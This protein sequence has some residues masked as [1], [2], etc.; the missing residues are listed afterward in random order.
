[1]DG[2]RYTLQPVNSSVQVCDPHGRVICSCNDPYD[3]P[4]DATRICA[5]LNAFVDGRSE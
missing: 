3:A 1:M 2:D 5:A 4:G